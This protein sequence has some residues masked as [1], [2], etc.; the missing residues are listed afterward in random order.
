MWREPAFR[1][2]TSSR[3]AELRKSAWTD[4][5]FSN[6]IKTQSTAVEPAAMRTF[7]RWAAAFAADKLQLDPPGAADYAASLKASI[8]YLHD[9]LLARLKWM[10]AQLASQGVAAAANSSGDQPPVA[11]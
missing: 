11:G 1:A 5:F 2:N 3:Y 6:E 4:D 9:W 8:T 10:D 7:K